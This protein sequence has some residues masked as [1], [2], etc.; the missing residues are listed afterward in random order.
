MGC[1][2]SLNRRDHA[3]AVS[4][5]R[6][7]SYQ[8]M[9]GAAVGQESLIWSRIDDQCI[10]LGVQEQG[11]LLATMRVELV[12]DRALLDAKL[13]T[14]WSFG[15]VQFP[16][17]ILSRAATRA[18]EER[19]GMNTL[20]RYHALLLAGHWDVD[21]VVGT[22]IKGSPRER[23]LQ[24]MGYQLYDS[25][26]GWGSSDFKS[27]SAVAIA[28]LKLSHGGKRARKICQYQVGL[29]LQDYPWV[30]SLPQPKFV[31]GIK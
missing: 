11:V 30:G 24:E 20:L 27:V 14:P 10:V 5:L 2:R 8:R 17:M 15:D 6:L 1:V 7:S 4:E 16:V 29:L 26:C 23:T 21:D 22:F 31:T 18:G 19:R 25:P 3:A 12:D 13:E 28:H 9:Q